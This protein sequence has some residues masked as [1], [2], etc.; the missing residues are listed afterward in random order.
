MEE[1]ARNKHIS[2]FGPFI[3][4]EEIQNRVTLL[5]ASKLVANYFIVSEI[6][7]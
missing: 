5:Q 6:K 4:Y 3:S 7:K 1:P 2:L